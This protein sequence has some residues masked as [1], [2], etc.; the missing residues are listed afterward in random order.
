MWAAAEAHSRDKRKKRNR[1]SRKVSEDAEAETKKQVGERKTG[2]EKI[3]GTASQKLPRQY[4]TNPDGICRVAVVIDDINSL[5]ETE[6]VF[7]PSWLS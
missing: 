7:Q 4:G 6:R 3:G 1:R 5:A 2:E